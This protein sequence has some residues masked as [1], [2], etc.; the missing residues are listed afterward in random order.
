MVLPTEL[1][2]NTQLLCER[3]SDYAPPHYAQLTTRNLV[4]PWASWCTTCDR[5]RL[6]NGEG[7]RTL[8]LIYHFDNLKSYANSW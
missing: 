5:G 2:V 8:T 4:S 6:L 7:A 1:L 3:D